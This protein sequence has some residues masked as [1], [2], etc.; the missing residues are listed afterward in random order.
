[1]KKLVR[2]WQ[3][4]THNGQRYTYYLVYYDEDGRRRQK[5]LG[6]ADKRKAERQRAQFERYLRM[7]TAESR[8][9]RFSEFSED[10]LRRSRGQLQYNTLRDYKSTMKQFIRMCSSR[11]AAT[12]V[13]R[14]RGGRA[15][16]TL[17]MRMGRSTTSTVA[18]GSS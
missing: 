1:M 3:R 8:S 13:F 18:S 9:M 16:G 2:L 17:V 6:H 4:P 15:S 5:A 12:T 10:S 14:N 7:G 11:W